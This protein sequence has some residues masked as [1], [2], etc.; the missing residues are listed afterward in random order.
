[1][2]NKILAI[3]V[4]TFLFSSSASATYAL[5]YCYPAQSFMWVEKYACF[6]NKYWSQ[7]AW[8]GLADDPGPASW[9]GNICAQ[10]IGPVFNSTLDISADCTKKAGAGSRIEYKEV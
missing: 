6:T 9:P 7:P 5:A 10:D 1:M 3:F 8:V 4:C 2:F